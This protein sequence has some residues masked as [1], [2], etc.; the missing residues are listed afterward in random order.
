LIEWER[1]KTALIALNVSYIHKNLALRWLWV[2]KPPQLEAQIFEGMTKLP[3][4]LL[5]D[6]IVYQPD[7]IAFSVYIF[8]LEA[9]QTLIKAL[10]EHLPQ[11]LIV[12]GGPEATYNP[13]PLFDA[14]VD[15][16]YRG[17]AELVFWA[18][19]LGQTVHGVQ[20]SAT[21]TAVVLRADLAVLETLGS[22]YFLEMDA[23]EMDHR[24]LYVESSRG[25]PFGCAYCLAAQDPHVRSFSEQ[26]MEE[27]FDQVSRTP[28]KQIKFLDRTF[29]LDP[30]R[31]MRLAQLCLNLPKD[32]TVHV[33]LVGD[34]LSEALIVL[35]TEHPER[36]RLELGVQSLNQQ[37][38]KA[39]GRHSDLHKLLNVVDRFAQAHL[40]QHTDLIAGLPHENLSSFIDS[41]N[42]LIRFDPYEVQV[43][44]LK[45]LHGSSMDK[46][47][48]SSGYHVDPNPPYQVRQTPWM[49]KSD[50]Q[51][52]EA[53]ALATEKAYNSQK[54][55][56]ELHLAFKLADPFACMKS[57][58]H[59]LLELSRPYTNQAFHLAIYA[60][61]SEHLPQER[62]KALVLHA[63]LRHA[64]ILPPKLFPDSIDKATLNA[65]RTLIN[66][67]D[68][69]KH[70]VISPR[71]DDQVGVLVWCYGSHP[72]KPLPITVNQW[73]ITPKETR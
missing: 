21:E 40:I 62:A 34:R 9:T 2:T 58:G 39:V 57:I 19:L 47:R 56:D 8:N 73:P 36:F 67:D 4:A 50:L 25:C 13:Q 18:D 31:A 15:R 44:I 32:V 66:A 29:N 33:E 20:H 10:R 49:S 70:I 11:A 60:G 28:V 30:Q 51:S 3:L 65:L 45:I 42:G 64:T 71:L 59:H 35:F 61:L 54:L 24:Y 52:V 7:V 27:F 17:E 37:T 14:G 46:Y 41:Y 23:L 72:Q 38:L 16:V 6:L 53:V 48:L 26:Y 5:E 63:Y 43:G 55:R 68:S 69:I 22:P 1:M 12:A